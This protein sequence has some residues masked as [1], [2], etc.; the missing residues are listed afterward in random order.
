MH[1]PNSLTAIL[2]GVVALVGVAAESA[3]AQLG[4]P[5]PA[6]SAVSAPTKAPSAPIAGLKKAEV[7]KPEWS[8][9]SRT[10]QTALEPLMTSWASMSP[11]QKRKWIALSRNYVAMPP[12]EKE[13]LHSRMKDWVKLSPQQRINA[14]LTFGETNQLTAEEKNAKWKAYQS[15][16]AEERSKLAAAAT[17]STGA[18][19]VVKPVSK[20]K[21]AVVPSMKNEPGQVP[22]IAVPSHN[23]D[24]N[25]LLPQQ[26]IQRS[27]STANAPA[28]ASVIST[29]A[30]AA[31]IPPVS[32]APSPAVAPAAPT[33]QAHDPAAAAANSGE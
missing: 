30:P 12:A 27:A 6:A 2:I 10:E 9:L 15:L 19:N 33:M 17:K 4:N 5:T 21:L 23:V 3:L 14:R 24:H 28:N 7:S 13:L 11:P 18:A 22:H 20:Q 26:P 25:T 16:S 8:E 1:R 29:V 32:P 31:A